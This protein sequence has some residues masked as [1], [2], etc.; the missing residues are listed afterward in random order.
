LEVCESKGEERRQLGGFSSEDW[1]PK[2][3]IEAFALILFEIIVGRPSTRE[4]SVPR[5]IPKFVSKIIETGLWLKSENK[6]SFNDIFK[7]LKW[8][9]FRIEDGVDSA[10]VSAF[11]SLVESAEH[12][13]K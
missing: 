11:V 12:P 5:D 9:K 8:N 3:D 4:I 10:E 6:F 7:I 2:M 1:T 13:E